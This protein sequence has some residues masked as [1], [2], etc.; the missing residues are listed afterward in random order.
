MRERKRLAKVKSKIT[1]IGSAKL[2]VGLISGGIN[3]NVVP[4]KITMRVDRRLIPEENGAR[5]ERAL[6]AL[7]KRAGKRKGIT[8]DCRR[9]I[10]AQPLKPL[11]GIDRLVE[12]LTR[13]G[14]RE[15]RTRIGVKGVPLYTDARHYSAAGIPTVLYGAGPRTILDVNAHGA[16][17]HI[18]L[19]DLKAATKVVEATLRDLLRS[20]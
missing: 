19:N 17:E 13:H 5:V 11:K 12:A 6:V 20:K 15:F 16:N 8:V 9:I 10:L 2:N 4:D 14:K 3:T 18:R 7:I 1:G